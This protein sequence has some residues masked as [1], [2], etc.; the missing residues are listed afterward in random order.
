MTDPGVLLQRHRPRLVYDSLEAYFADSAA[1]WTDSPTNV[2]RRPD[3]SLLARPPQLALSLLGPQLYSDSRPVL[4]GDAIGDTTRDYAAHAAALHRLP[5]YR[6]RVYGH[7]RRDRAGALWLQYWLFY[8]Y[9]DFQLLGPLLSGGKHEGDWELVQLRLN[10]SEQP[11]L[12]VYS[13]HK[14]AGSRPWSAVRKAGQTPLV[15]VARGSHA[16]YFTPGAH[17][18]GVWFDQ[19]DGKGP[20]ITPTVEVLGDRQPAWVHWPGSWGDTKASASPLDSASPRSPGRRP[21]WSNPAAL[22]PP[23]RALGE[24]LRAPVPPA[25]P[26]ISARRDDGRA[27]VAYEAEPEAYALTVGLRATGSDE[28]ATT[29]SF[30][31]DAPRG[32]VELPVDER[33]HDVW[34][35]AVGPGGTASEGTNASLP[36]AM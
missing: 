32:Q 4:A 18:T 36:G 9:N 6:D 19:A 11:D 13:Q 17:W 12:A 2:L 27:I 25:P 30:A 3:G 35:S 8:Y 10:A 34:A 1:I 7:A 23:A 31:L 26:R 29:R 22:V 14:T 15:Y 21:H 16:N 33:P 20:A 28:P 5:R 24:A